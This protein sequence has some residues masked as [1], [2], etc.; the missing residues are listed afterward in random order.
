MPVHGTQVAITLPG[1]RVIAEYF[2]PVPHRRV[3][4]QIRSG[5]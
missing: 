1:G 5:A 2:V 3:A 4:E